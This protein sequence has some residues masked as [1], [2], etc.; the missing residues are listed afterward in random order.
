MLLLKTSNEDAK[1]F[2]LASG[3]VATEIIKDYYK[4]IEPP[5]CFLLRKSMKE[6]YEIPTSTSTTSGE[7]SADVEH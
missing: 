5:D 7:A 6:G 1:Q 3:F 2:Y 4:R